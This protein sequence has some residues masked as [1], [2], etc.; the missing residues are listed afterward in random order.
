MQMKTISIRILVL[1]VFLTSFLLNA[2]Y[3]SELLGRLLVEKYPVPIR[4]LEDLLQKRHQ[5]SLEMNQ[6]SMFFDIFNVRIRYTFILI[7]Y[8]YCIYFFF[9]QLLFHKSFQVPSNPIHQKILKIMILPNKERMTTTDGA[10]LLNKLNDPHIVIIGAKLLSREMKF[11]FDIHMI[12]LGIHIPVSLCC[13][14]NSQLSGLLD[15][16]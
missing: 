11:S 8:S 12:S 15:F 2:F 5:Y 10:S 7:T 4:S 6:D 3:T 13:Q 1:T 16:Q 14:N 9:C